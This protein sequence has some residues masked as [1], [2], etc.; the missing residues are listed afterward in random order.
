[1]SVSIARIRTEDVA[2]VASLART[3]WFEHYPDIIGWPQIHYMLER[4]Y[5]HGVIAAELA[6]GVEWHFA[7]FDGEPCGFAAWDALNDSIKLHKLYV[8]RSARER[9]LGR[10][11]IDACAA[12][13]QRRAARDVQLAVNKR[14]VVAIRAYLRVGFAF[15][16]AVCVP[17]GHGFVMDD[18][19][20]ARPVPVT[21][22]S[23]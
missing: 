3:I 2:T 8:L 5:A 18:Y 6:R 9:G 20:M 1:M 21:P 4:G 14:N 7:M 22:A 13:A 19:V 15:R 16:R 12:D 17:I 23:S 11:L 10:A